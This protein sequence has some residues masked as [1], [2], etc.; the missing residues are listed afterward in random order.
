MIVGDQLS[1]VRVGAEQR[2]ELHAGR[3]AA[4]ELV[5]QAE[6]G[7]GRPASDQA[8]SSAGM[9]SVSSSRARVLRVARI[10]AMVPAA[11]PLR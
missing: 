9:S 1:R 5:E 6:G 7:V 10:A 8:W 11:D 3:Q 4:T 2:E